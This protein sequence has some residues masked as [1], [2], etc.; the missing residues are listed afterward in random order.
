M[1]GLLPTRS[2]RRRLKSSQ[3]P[4]AGSAEESGYGPIAKT[5]NTSG[6][7]ITKRT[8]FLL[9][10]PLKPELVQSLQGAGGHTALRIARREGKKP[11]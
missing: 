6:I 2:R 9:S 8:R 4:R 10:Y 3:V 1:Q 7:T 11:W 5:L